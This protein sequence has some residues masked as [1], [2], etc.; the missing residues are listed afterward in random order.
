MFKDFIAVVAKVEWF[1]FANFQIFT[2]ISNDILNKEPFEFGL[3][4]V[5][6]RKL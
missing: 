4:S 1:D 6:S 2:N 3:V 5:Y